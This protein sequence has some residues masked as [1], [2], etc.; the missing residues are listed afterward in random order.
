MKLVLVI[1]WIAVAAALLC[2]YCLR[3][4]SVSPA[5]LMFAGLAALMLWQIHPVAAMPP[6][7]ASAFL[8]RL[9]VYGIPAFSFVAGLV[10]WL[11]DRRSRRSR[12]TRR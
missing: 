10:F 8:F 5:L 4:R 11:T 1:C 3:G 6:D 9:F 2:A 12:T 7:P